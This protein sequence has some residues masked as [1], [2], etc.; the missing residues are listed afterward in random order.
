MRKKVI[1]FFVIICILSISCISILTYCKPIKIENIDKSKRIC[2]ELYITSSKKYM[3][4]EDFLGMI[5]S[6]VGLNENIFDMYCYGMD[7]EGFATDDLKTGNQY[8]ITNDISEVEFDKIYRYD[9]LCYIACD[10]NIL[11]TYKKTYEYRGKNYITIKDAIVMIEACLEDTETEKGKFFEKSKEYQRL[12][13]NAQKN[14]V[15][16]NDMIYWVPIDRKATRD[17]IYTLLNR[18]LNQKRYKYLSDAAYN[19]SK[20]Q[21]DYDRS[22]T[23]K[24]YLEQTQ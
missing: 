19:E 1:I 18:L 6:V 16:K 2:D 24:E 17:E 9:T 22:I 14:I 21:I 13:E 8:Q 10:V 3:S 5:L 12:F 4:R 15:N 7:R 11:Q 20:A 23:Y